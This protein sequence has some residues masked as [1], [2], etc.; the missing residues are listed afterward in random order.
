MRLRAWVSLC[1]L[2]PPRCYHQVT[3]CG[4]SPPARRGDFP[5]PHR[6]HEHRCNE[7]ARI[8]IID[9]FHG[10]RREL[11]SGLLPAMSTFLHCSIP[12]VC[13]LSWDASQLGCSRHDFLE[14]QMPAIVASVSSPARRLVLE[15][16]TGWSLVARTA[17]CSTLR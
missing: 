1:A 9:V 12:M 7:R 2:A 4:F 14:L 3:S 6:R 11:V 17:S 10:Y 15:H 5:E 8:L 13:A 16:R